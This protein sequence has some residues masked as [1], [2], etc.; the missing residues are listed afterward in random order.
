MATKAPKDHDC[1]CGGACDSCKAAHVD[2]KT[3]Y[4][5][6][7]MQK[8]PR[9]HGA[10]YVLLTPD[11]G[12]G[13][14]DPQDAKEDEFETTDKAGF[15]FK[16]PGT[17]AARERVT[18]TK[19]ERVLGQEDKFESKAQQGFM[20]VHHPKLAK[21]FAAKTKD[22]KD[23]PAHVD[24][25]ASM[26]GA[27]RTD[28]ETLDKQIANLGS[29]KHTPSNGRYL[30]GEELKKYEAHADTLNEGTEASNV[31]PDVEEES[32]VGDAWTQ[33]GPTFGA[34][35]AQQDDKDQ[36]EEIHPPLHCRS[37]F[38]DPARMQVHPYLI[39]RHDA[40]PETGIAQ[41]IDIVECYDW[42]KAGP[43][44]LWE[45]GGG[46]ADGDVPAASDLYIIDGHHRAMA[47]KNARHIGVTG[48]LEG[49]FN[50]TARMVPTI[51]FS[52]RDGWTIMLARKLGEAAN[53]GGGL[54]I[55]F[56]DDLVDAGASRILTA[57]EA[58]KL[59]KQDSAEELQCRVDS[60]E[61]SEVFDVVSHEYECITDGLRE[62]VLGV[63]R[64]IITRANTPTKWG[65]VYRFPGPLGD[66]ITKANA[67][68]RTRHVHTEMSHPALISDRSGCDATGCGP[69]FVNNGFDHATGTVLNV[70]MPDLNGWVWASRE[71]LDTED[72]RKIWAAA[73]AG[74]PRPVSVRWFYKK[75]PRRPGIPLALD[76]MTY[77]DVA[78]PAMEG[79]GSLVPLLDDF[80]QPGIGTGETMTDPTYEGEG[81]LGEPFHGVNKNMANPYPRDNPTFEELDTAADAAT[82]TAALDA[83]TTTSAPR[84]TV[85]P[86]K[87]P[88][89][90]RA[91]IRALG[92]A[93]RNG[94]VTTKR[95]LQPLN[96]VA[97]QAISDAF[98]CGHDVREY[99][100]SYQGAIRDALEAIPGFHPDGDSIYVQLGN[101]IGMDPMGGWAR[102][103]R[104]LG[105]E[106][107]SNEKRNLQGKTSL[108]VVPETV[109]SIRDGSDKASDED[110]K[111]EDVKMD[112]AE[113]AKMDAAEKE[114]KEIKEK[115]KEKDK[116]VEAKMDSLL[117]SGHRAAQLSPVALKIVKRHVKQNAKSAD[118]VSALLDEGVRNHT[119]GNAGAAFLET[120]GYG[121]L[122]AGASGRNSADPR[123]TVTHEPRPNTAAIEKMRTIMD[124]QV[125][126]GAMMGGDF[127]P[128]NPY[129]AETK[130]LRAH[131]RKVMQPVIEAWE[132]RQAAKRGAQAFWGSLLDGCPDPMQQIEAEM[133]A[134]GHMDSYTTAISN[135]P[136]QPTIAHVMYEQAFQDQRMLKFAGVIGPDMGDEGTP[137]AMAW[138]LQ[139][140]IGRVFKVL[141]ETYVNPT[142]YGSSYGSFNNGLA[143][144]ENVG[145]PE[146]TTAYYWDTFFPSWKKNATSETIEALRSIGNGP[147]NLSLTARLL[148]HCGAYKSR[149]VDQLLANEIPNTALEYAA[150]AVASET[151]TSGN[152]G[153]TNQTVFN[154]ANVT[155]VNLNP[156]HPASTA[157]TYGTDDYVTYPTP[158]VNPGVGGQAPIA[159]MRVLGGTA[160]GQNAAPYF[161]G[162]STSG[163][164][165]TA[166][167]P[168]VPPR[169][170][171]GLSNAGADQA[172]TLNPIA[173]TAPGSMILGSLG[174]DGY[175]YPSPVNIANNQTPT[176]AVDYG[177]GTIV[178]ASG[179]TGSAGVIAQTVTIQYSYGTNYDIF[180]LVPGMNGLANFATGETPDQF[181]NRLLALIDFSAAQM[182][183]WPR[184]CAPDLLLMNAMVSPNI[185]NAANFWKFQS[186]KDT[187]LYPDEEFFAS[188]NGVNFARLNTPWWPG[189]GSM[190]LTRRYSTKYA[191]DTV[192][193]LRGPNVKYDSAGNYIAGEGYFG[194]E[195]SCICTP[196]VKDGNGSIV[197]PV[198]RQ[199]MLLQGQATY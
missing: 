53:L 147:I 97:A 170:T 50:E 179:V 172:G 32:S 152:H 190:T 126:N 180:P 130:S 59:G 56:Q 112:E 159:A 134:I 99:V 175:I 67:R 31:L 37:E 122:P 121:G 138:E 95:A 49:Q 163:V 145:I 6:D 177:N 74:Q 29:I 47:A 39:H 106:N 125:A 169:P 146:G 102:D 8:V 73:Q 161:G 63:L 77:D 44:L 154:T 55:K 114:A 194:G 3:E 135:V 27:P 41:T 195:N 149:T 26:Q 116:E 69:K 142:G 197:N 92:A 66:A 20:F 123:V 173:M 87:T 79:A 139:R 105:G 1:K 141:S 11:E 119:P 43:I 65:F 51:I 89:E 40:N 131:N 58:E 30:S 133:A 35:F 192:W 183:S 81:G 129:S 185:T 176:F 21:E 117:Y 188:R 174:P 64:Q 115:A 100:A 7:H 120:R 165:S 14:Y 193:E 71:V 118:E 25:A 70:E 187:D 62:G 80:D 94:S 24:S 101:E 104:S 75:D 168:I 199:I 155:T 84:A 28:F 103:L 15:T 83:A 96:A 93:V 86:M 127:T 91:A 108:E 23:L 12:G 57:K 128:P 157:P 88:E 136:N 38:V 46:A 4:P 166:K 98:E 196:Q 178:F 36:I 45:K 110:K 17:K 160:V 48:I 111:D 132:D 186:P 113:K 171:L 189:S 61:L 182:A 156:A 140:G 184:F 2:G 42:S 148:Y 54:K 109:T 68:F 151:Y 22:F 90:I 164:N 18:K 60:G 198:G 137:N 167:T 124:D 162:G 16:H 76:L 33:A 9:T 150:V 52:E 158:G 78:V 153:L 34:S 144:P 19:Q 143:T 107:V 5:E 72:G 10:A 85:T 191:M 82:T 181:N 13:D